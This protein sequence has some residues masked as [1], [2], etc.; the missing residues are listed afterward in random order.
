MD[1]DGSTPE[2][3]EYHMTAIALARAALHDDLEETKALLPAS[4]KEAVAVIVCLAQEVVMLT[5]LAA[6]VLKVTPDEVLED[7]TAYHLDQMKD[8]GS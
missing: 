4:R 6:E 2:E 8:D 3:R 1:H 5:E 7:L